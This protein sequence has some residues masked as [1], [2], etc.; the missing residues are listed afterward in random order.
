MEYVPVVYQKF[1]HHREIFIE[2]SESEMSINP[3]IIASLLCRESRSYSIKEPLLS[4]ELILIA[5]VLLEIKIMKRDSRAT[6]V[7]LSDSV[8][9]NNAEFLLTTDSNAP[10]NSSWNLVARW[11]NL[12]AYRLNWSIDDYTSLSCTK[13]WD[14]AAKMTKPF[15]WTG[16]GSSGAAASLTAESNGRLKVISYETMLNGDLTGL[17]KGMR[18]NFIREDGQHGI[19][20]DQPA[21]SFGKESNESIT[22]T[23]SFLCI[24][25]PGNLSSLKWK[26]LDPSL[27]STSVSVAT[28]NFR[29]VMRA[30]GKLKEKDLSLGLEFSGFDHLNK[31]RVF[32]VAKHALSTHCS[33]MYSFPT[34]SNITD[35][36]AATIP[37]VYLTAYFAL[38]HKADIK[39]G[40]S[41]LIHAG[42]GGVG[43]AAIRVALSRGLKVFTTCS[44]SAKRQFIKDTFGLRDHEI[45]DSRSDS[46]VETVMRGTNSKGVDIALNQLS[47]DLQIATLRCMVSRDFK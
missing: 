4:P 12:R 6:A 31:K 16:D 17:S 35:A 40:Q 34:P 36:Q 42:T 37:V 11:A 41:I 3:K 46:F 25:R 30:M 26:D 32:G 33:P 2:Y 43:I 1:S 14:I 47:G 27:H 20:L 23:N 44:S 7:V 22:S 28:L 38:C 24:E 8:D 9:V 18:H 45:G 19:Y 15:I 21:E 29:D 5:Q 10:K 39:E 13:E